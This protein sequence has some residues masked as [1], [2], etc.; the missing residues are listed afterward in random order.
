MADKDLTNDDDQVPGDQGAPPD[1]EP[2]GPPISDKGMILTDDE[3]D[4]ELAAFE[5][6]KEQAAAEGIDI[7][8]AD[9][10]PA[11][12][13][14]GDGT[15]DAAPPATPGP[16]DP[17]P[18]ADPPQAQP[19][20]D[21][22][23]PDPP[24]G[25]QPPKN[26]P[27]ATFVQERN[28]G[29]ALARKVAELE[30]Q[31]TAYREVANKTGTPGQDQAGEPPP[32]TSDE[33]ITRLNAEKSANWAKYEDSE[34]ESA[35]LHK[36]NSVLDD[37]IL[38]LKV[39]AR[40]AAAPQGQHVYQDG[41]VLDNLNRLRQ[42]FPVLGI[43]SKDAMRPFVGEAE[44]QLQAEGY[45]LDGNNPQHVREIHN[46]AAQLADDRFKTVYA[47]PTPAPGDIPPGTPPAGG[48]APPA[49]KP[50]QQ[51]SQQPGG[52][53]A[54]PS[55]EAQERR[56]KLALSQAQPPNLGEHGDG[57]RP[58]VLTNEQVE[59]QMESMTED[60]RAEFLAANPLLQTRILGHAME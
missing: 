40:V 1:P 55:P 45:I 23:Q 19:P 2:S 51:P 3:L 50:G 22:Q 25:A 31:V 39:A 8:G 43:L 9:I 53:P 15:G 59:L 27:V 35:D 60:Q 7:M 37:Q 42:E 56:D 38:D 49:A 6:I 18:P 26:V 41:T 52:D 10:V 13:P 30:G 21:G 44:S 29:N 48:D 54:L 32:E 34:M 20:A 17:P 58:A 5:K 46:R 4:P 57:A 28:R 12:P 16:Q 24:Q 33:T 47:P 14:P 36:A 11:T